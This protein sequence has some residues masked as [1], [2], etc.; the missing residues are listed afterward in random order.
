MNECIF[1]G[2]FSLVR[3]FME[4]KQSFVTVFLIILLAS[5]SGKQKQFVVPHAINALIH[6]HFEN[7]RSLQGDIQII[8]IS[9]GTKTNSDLTEQILRIK[10]S[11]V[12]L[13]IDGAE[14]RYVETNNAEF[15]FE[16]STILFFDTIATFKACATRIDW[17]TNERRQIYHHLVYV[18]GLT[19][20]DII[21]HFPDGFAI[22]HVNFLMHETDNSIELVASF[23]FT[24]QACRQIQLKTINRFDL[25][26]VKWENSTFYPGK[27]K[28][29]HGCKLYISNE[30]Y[31]FQGKEI[32]ELMELVFVSQLNATLVLKPKVDL[33]QCKK[34]D[35]TRQEFYSQS[36]IQFDYFITSNPIMYSNYIVAI[37]PGVPYTDLERM[38][39]MFDFELW[40][41]ITVTFA[42]ALFTTLMLR[43]VSR[44]VR[45]FIVGR[46]VQNPTM[47]LLSIFLTGSQA[48]VPGRNFARFL[49]TL[50]VIWSL[51]IRTCHQSML[52]QL[53]QAD[54]R[55]PTIKTIDELFKADIKFYSTVKN[56][57]DDEYFEEQLDLPTTRLAWLSTESFSNKNISDQQVESNKDF[58]RCC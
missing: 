49:F 40:I 29:Y 39:L 58:G 28:N 46:Y 14:L 15:Q 30:K 23:M 21:E 13:T 2:V 51:I 55:K 9:D 16:S 32:G 27:H 10:N 36:S 24:P 34:C 42:I 44:K 8:C 48:R 7:S 52:F 43:F 26:D 20:S 41:A 33:F 17:M 31:S 3:A 4:F 54:L 22:D 47:N 12:T 18:P 50:F 5:A 37:S 53:M 57:V 25:A 1:F 35:L 45:N 56:Y 38:F 11:F 6:E 19:T